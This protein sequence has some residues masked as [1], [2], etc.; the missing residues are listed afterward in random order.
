MKNIN[1]NILINIFI[2]FIFIDFCQSKNIILPF[3]K[4]SVENLNKNKTINDLILF[5][6]YT[7]ITMGTP[8]QIVAHFIE[9]NDF[10]FMYQEVL[11]SR[12]DKIYSRQDYFKLNNFWFDRRKSQSY[13]LDIDEQICSDI[14]YFE[15]LDKS[16][17]KVENFRATFLNYLASQNHQCGIIGL[18]IPTKPKDDLL[19]INIDFIS[20]LKRKELIDEYYFTI[21][22]ERNNDLF[23]YNDDL[24]LGK[25]IIGESPYKL[26]PNQFKKE[27]EVVLY[28]KDWSL[29]IEQANFNYKDI[30]YKEEDI[31]FKISFVNGFIIG[32]STYKKKISKAFFDDLIEK[33]LCRIDIIEDNINTNEYF[34]Y[35]CDNNQEMHKNIELFPNLYFHIKMNGLMFNFTHKDLFK[36][37]ENRLYFLIIFKNIELSSSGHVWTFGDTFLK[38]Y[39]TFFNSD[40]KTI[41][42]FKNQINNIEINNSNNFDHNKANKEK[43]IEND[44]KNNV[45]RT[46]IEIFMGIIIFIILFLLYKKYRSTRKLHANELEDNNYEYKA[47]DNKNSELFMSDN[48]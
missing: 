32:T 38:K 1:E 4:F 37:Y 36:L 41:L 7:N 31:Q 23:N 29:I 27:D 34:L 33:K 30:E 10:S 13:F 6:I 16:I 18:N 28:L 11:L 19:P 15:T 42:L 14:Y 22:Y 25:V 5:H 2:L 44:T 48:F 40:S 12:N 43:D 39:T 3:K 46:L 20:E 9:L 24:F 8:S 47:K 45:S 17:I 21:E 26:Y 35:S